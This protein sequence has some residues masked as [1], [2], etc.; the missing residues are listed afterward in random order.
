MT[1][2]NVMEVKE[3][4]LTAGRLIEIWIWDLLHPILVLNIVTTNK[5]LHSLWQEYACRFNWKCRKKWINKSNWNTIWSIRCKATARLGILRHLS[6]SSL[7]RTSQWHEVFRNHLPENRV[8][9]DKLLH[10]S[11]IWKAS[12]LSKCN[13]QKGNV[14]CFALMGLLSYRS[15]I[16]EMVPLSNRWKLVAAGLATPNICNEPGSKSFPVTNLISERLWITRLC[17][18]K[19]PTPIIGQLYMA[20]NY[21][22]LWGSIF[23]QLINNPID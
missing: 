17:L 9:A 1:V 21:L 23:W 7:L 3:M 4:E 10:A 20:E 8:L 5:P 22:K 14:F 6:P 11:H 13:M 16:G 15:T 2:D 12:P 19:T 18:A